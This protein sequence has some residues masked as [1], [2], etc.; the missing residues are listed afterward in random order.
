MVACVAADLGIANASLWMCSDALARGAVV[1][2]MA[3]YSLDPITAY[4][5]FPGGR[6]PSQRTRAFADYL[7]RAIA[8]RQ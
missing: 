1:E 5:V 3:D 8:S 7:E 6:R 2:I 4:V